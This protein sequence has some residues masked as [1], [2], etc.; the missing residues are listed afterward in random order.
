MAESFSPS[1]RSTVNCS[2]HHHLDALL[3]PPPASSS[4]SSP[5]RLSS[6]HLIPEEPVPDY[7]FKLEAP[8]FSE[9]G[10]LGARNSEGE[11]FRWPWLQEHQGQIWSPPSKRAS[12]PLDI[13][14]NLGLDKASADGNRGR[15]HS[16]VRAWFAFMEDEMHSTPHRPMDPQS[17]LWAKLNEEWLFMKFA[18]SL[19]RDRGV[20]VGTV[21]CYC[22]ATQG[23]H[24]R[25][26]GI[27]LAAGLKL[28][29]LP[30]MLKGLR[31]VFG[32]PEVKLRRGFAPQALRRAMDLLLDPDNPTHANYRAAIA[33][34]F[35]GLLR[36]A[37]FCLKDGKKFNTRL[38]LTRFDVKELSSDLAIIMMAPCK[39]MK[40]LG[41][42]TS[43]LVIGGGGRYIDAVAELHNLMRV[44]PTPVDK[45]KLTPLFRDPKTNEPILYSNV[46]ALLKTM[47]HSIG[48]NAEQFGTHSLRIGGATA[49]FAMGADETVIRTMGRWSSDIHR[50]YVR[51]CF[52]RCKEWT[53]M[54]GSAQVTDVARIFDDGEGDM[55]DDDD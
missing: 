8:V 1:S 35:Q 31:R 2:I 16:G 51:A 22:S 48:E 36:S 34:A 38:H 55:E 28:E 14:I 17:P 54:A 11:L 46:L 29:R 4:S 21:R 45:E 41:G 6:V 40:H 39:N 23:W 42:K 18:C 33:T 53:K 49:L 27:K 19:I 9:H 25:E 5:S 47:M 43:P 26:H 37:E 50:L 24:A 52:E 3:L 44:D 10:D 20:T 30:Q 12:H 13:L 32:D 15:L 7:D